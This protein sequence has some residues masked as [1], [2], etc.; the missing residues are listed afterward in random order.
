M[1]R[2]SPGPAP[3]H[4]TTPV[5][6]VISR[7]AHFMGVRRGR[8]TCSASRTLV[9]L[10]STC[11]TVLFT[12]GC[13]DGTRRIILLRRLTTRVTS[14]SFHPHLPRAVAPDRTRTPTFPQKTA[15]LLGPDAVALERNRQ[16]VGSVLPVG[17]FWRKGR[18]RCCIGRFLLRGEPC[19]Q[20]PAANWE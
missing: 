3:R 12:T 1:K 18:R 8:G 13:T 16:L 14:L 11:S 5:F 4:A 17:R 7:A 6:W 20:L 15:E 10:S 19:L 9:G 2:L